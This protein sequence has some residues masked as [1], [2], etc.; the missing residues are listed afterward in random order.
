MKLSWIANRLHMGTKTHLWP[1]LYWHKEKSELVNTKNPCSYALGYYFLRY[2]SFLCQAEL[3][4][5][6]LL[7]LTTGFATCSMF[8]LRS[9]STSS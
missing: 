2:G 7:P 9:N 8:N 5:T 3:C 1:P 4:R 6:E